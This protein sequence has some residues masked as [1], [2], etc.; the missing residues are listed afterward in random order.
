MVKNIK[1]IDINEVAVNNTNQETSLLRDFSGLLLKILAVVVVFILLFSFVFAA[2]RYDDLS[3]TSI[4]KEGDMV[5]AYRWDKNYS[6]G[7]VCAFRYNDK[8]TCSRV[9]AKEQD[10]VNITN[11]GLLVNGDMIQEHDIYKETTQVKDGV[12]FPLT[13]PNGCIF[14][15][16]DNRDTAI[17]SRIFG[18]IDVNKTDGKVIG[19]F[20]HR[21]I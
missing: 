4:I 1:N 2:F 18:C 3:M 12:T 17:D 7:D 6:S 5:V 11:K 21:S 9:V 15:L 8:T 13:V 16:G 19:I 20:K 14:V 10:T